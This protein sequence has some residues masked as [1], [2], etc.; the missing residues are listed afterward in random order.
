ML[1]KFTACIGAYKRD[2]VLTPVF[3]ALE[4]AM[5]IIIPLLMADM[6][7][8]GITGGNMNV[9]VKIGLVLVLLC[10]ISLVTGFLS[11]WFAARASAGFAKNLR[12]KMFY[13]IQG[14]SYTSIDK[15]STSGLV[16]RLTT[17]VTNTQNAFQM[18]IR[19]CARAPLMIIFSVVMVFSI[20]ARLAWVF[21]AAIPILA[22]GLMLIMTKATPI[23]ARVFKIYDKLNNVVQE[24]LRGIRVV[25][26]YVR[27]EHETEKFKETSGD[28]YQNFV[29]AEKILAFNSPLMQFCM[30]GCTL[31]IC[32]LGAQMIVSETFTT[33]QLMGLLTYAVQILVSL[34]M[35]SM[36]FVMVTMSKAS[37]QR[38]SEVL[39]E[40]TDMQNGKAGA[41]KDGGVRF[42][43]VSFGYRGKDGKLCLKNIDV[44]IASGQTV[45]IIGGTGSGKSTLTQL[46]PRLY[47]VTQGSVE[48]GGLDVRDYDLAALRSQV[49]MVLQKNVLFSGSIK[50]N[51]RW[52]N[53]DATDTELTHVCKLAQADEFVSSF[54]NGYDTYIDQG[55]SNVSGGQKQRLCIARALLKKPKI[56]ILDDS[57]SA[58][59]TKTDA[60]IRGAFLEEIPDTTKII[61]A[62][63]VSSVQDADQILVMDDGHISA[64]GTHAEL[65]ETS[66]IYREVYESQQKGGLTDDAA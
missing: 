31:L 56:L 23:F 55:G 45:G 12:Q 63:R 28:I 51:L 48:V 46:I 17:D 21:A 64:I 16:T 60:L 1:K 59:D 5:D 35:L 66:P 4:V 38:I 19:I 29:K 53:K 40:S 18:I 58:V 24:N 43:D 30:Y 39:N 37:V 27:E 54:P 50:D 3:V 41:L 61:I 15:F 13:D 33:G 14:F 32:W 26:S 2:T 20:N 36:V 7:D 25:K 10:V 9:I 49:A 6:I 42:K 65:L 44:N 47:D 52:G 57:T 62:Q 8:K 11:G 22:T 34:M